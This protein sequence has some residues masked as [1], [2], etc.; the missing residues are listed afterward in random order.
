MM[1]ALLFL[2]FN[3]HDWGRQFRLFRTPLERWFGCD[4]PEFGTFRQGAPENT[5]SDTSRAQ[6]ANA[7]KFCRYETADKKSTV[8]QSMALGLAVDPKRSAAARTAPRCH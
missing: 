1:R 7:W 2:L 8:R 5:C 6:P 3:R 4:P